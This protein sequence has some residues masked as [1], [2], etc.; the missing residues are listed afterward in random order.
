[1]KKKKMNVLISPA[2]MAA[3]YH[4]TT[5]A[6]KHFADD[7]DIHLC[8]TNPRHLIAASKIATSFTQV[9]PFVDPN[10]RKEMLTIIKYKSID[11]FLPMMEQELCLFSKDDL[12][13]ARLG[14]RCVSIYHTVI[15]LL[16]NKRLLLQFLSNHGIPVPREIKKNDIR[17]NGNYFVKPIDGYGSRGSRVVSGYDVNPYFLDKTML[18]EEY[19][20]GP[21][22]TI[23]IFN[24]K[25]FFSTICRERIETK[26]GICTKARI[27]FDPNLQ[28]LAQH[29]CAVIPL[30]PAICIQVMKN[31]KNKWVVTDINPRLGAGTS[32]ASAYGWSLG[33]ALFSHL[34]DRNPRQ[35]FTKQKRETYVVR[36][37]SDV[38]M[39][40]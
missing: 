29:V 6:K 11:I 40:K 28:M 30:P 19:C 9:K 39:D 27:F 23:E 7:I 13:L 35:W 38:I 1:M 31:S 17:K 16:Q 12:D 8:D 3:V 22:V 25:G 10:H 32:M 36:T 18:V 37:Y 14:V 21:E 2:G 4:L 15:P 24:T 5:I 20:N 34:L 33:S 26:G